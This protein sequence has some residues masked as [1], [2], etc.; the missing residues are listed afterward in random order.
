MTA[1]IS[2]EVDRRDAVVK[3]PNAALRF[4]PSRDHVRPDD[5]PI[6]DGR[7]LEADDQAR[8]QAPSAAAKADAES[9]RRRRHVWVVEP[10]GLLRAVAVVT[11]IGDHRS[12]EVVSGGIEPGT[13]LVVGIAPADD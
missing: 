7:A 8:G 5:R 13:R 12:T 6:L 9:E 4:Y 11:G 1:E 10:D 3:V 2:F